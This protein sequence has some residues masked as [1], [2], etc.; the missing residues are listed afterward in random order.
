MIS[1]EFS[2]IAHAIACAMRDT[3]CATDFGPSTKF[4]KV[5]GGVMVMQVGEQFW[6]SRWDHAAGGAVL[7]M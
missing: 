6:L 3:R 2:R 7:A 1:F 4:L 5:C